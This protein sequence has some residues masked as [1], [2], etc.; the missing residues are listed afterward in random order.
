MNESFV[1]FDWPLPLRFFLALAVS[2]L[3]GLERE[4][5][6]ITRKPKIFAGVRTYS[7]IGVYGFGCAWL[8]HN[9]F[10][11]VLPIGMI[12][13]TV[14]IIINYLAK[15]KETHPGWTSEVAALLTFIVGVLSMVAE[16]WVPMALGIVATFLLSEKANLEKFVKRLDETEFLAVLKFLLVTIIILP[17]LPNQD[18]TEYRLN[19]R[20]IWQIVVLVSAVGFV[21]YFLSKRYG[22][23]VGLWLS[24]LLGGIVSSTAVSI[25]CG[26]IAQ[27][28]PERTINALQASLMA[29]SVMYIRVLILIWILAP[30]MTRYFWAKL[31]ILAVVGLILS[32]SV[33]KQPNNRKEH[34]VESLN[35]P[36]EIRPALIFAVMFV[37]MS[38]ITSL[39][40]QFYGHAGMIA[41]AFITGVT[42]I[43]PFIL[44]LVEHVDEYKMLIVTAVIVAM[45]SNTIIKGIYFGFLAKTAR[46]ATAWRFALWAVLHIPIILWPTS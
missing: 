39:V 6:M 7:L 13:V 5:A 25:A 32:F 22:S 43:D 27:N 30:E 2:F 3:V 23:K 11:W 44:S 15:L 1:N 35:N 14:L 10:Q 37:I 9:D 21:G 18:F 42:D 20:K 19:P 17:V 34:R 28:A 29:S 12:S 8:Y 16:I 45:M 31:M 36:F 41:L 40:T 33:R 24:G 26:R 4:S 38:V 46:T